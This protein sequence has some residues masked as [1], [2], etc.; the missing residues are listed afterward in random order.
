M[1][2]DARRKLMDFD[3]SR[4]ASENYIDAITA[5]SLPYFERELWSPDACIAVGMKTLG[6]RR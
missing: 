5:T 2:E 4:R 6:D 1:S 3:R